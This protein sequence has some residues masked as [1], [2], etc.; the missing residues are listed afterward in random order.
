MNFIK[1]CLILS[2]IIFI[3]L[4]VD[5]QLSIELSSKNKL[6]KEFQYLLLSNS[7][8]NKNDTINESIVDLV[9]PMLVDSIIS[10][11]KQHHKLGPL[12]WLIHTF[13]NFK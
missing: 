13:G 2:C 12:G 3:G 1:S 9:Q 7:E 10:K 8:I 11:K 6:D 4:S 5:A